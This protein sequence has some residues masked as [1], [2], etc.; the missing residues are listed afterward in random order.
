MRYLIPVLVLASC[1]SGSPSSYGCTCEGPPG[2]E[3]AEQTSIVFSGVLDLV[4][5]HLQ[6]HPHRPEAGV[7]RVPV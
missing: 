2:P 7:I 3:R 5:V 6:D 1:V 4:V